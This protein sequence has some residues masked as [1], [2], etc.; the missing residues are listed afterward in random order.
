[1]KT[2]IRFCIT[3]GAMLAYP[4]WTAAAMDLSAIQ[5]ATS[6][7]NRC[8]TQVNAIHNLGSS[9]P[10]GFLDW[11]VLKDN[12]AYEAPS[13][14]ANI[15]DFSGMVDAAKSMLRRCLS[16]ESYGKARLVQATARDAPTKTKEDGAII[17]HY[18]DAQANFE[19]AIVKALAD[20]KTQALLSG[21]FK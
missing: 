7:L 10:R 20:R 12:P 18:I 11:S 9:A 14:I 13:N 15:K 6:D 2:N 3:V 4:C 5:T 1:M 21:A 16:I 19:A 8:T 17:Q